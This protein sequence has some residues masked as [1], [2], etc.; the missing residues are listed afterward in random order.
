MY[1]ILFLLLI[2]G[3]ICVW[4]LGYKNAPSVG[5]KT[6][7]FIIT[8]LLELLMLCVFLAFGDSKKDKK[9]SEKQ[10]NIDKKE[11]KHNDHSKC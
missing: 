1:I 4:F 10:K 11:K 5:W 2:A 8:A 7:F 6:F 9:Q 3:E